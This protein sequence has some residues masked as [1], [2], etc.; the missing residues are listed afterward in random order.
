MMAAVGTGPV[1]S[2]GHWMLRAFAALAALL[3]IAVVVCLE[4]LPSASTLTG[5]E[6]RLEATNG[7]AIALYNLRSAPL[8]RYEGA[9]GAPLRVEVSTARLATLTRSAVAQ[10]DLPVPNV[11]GGA[12]S[13]RGVPPSDGR[14]SVEIRNGRQAPDAGIII[15][16]PGSGTMELGIRAAQTNLLAELAIVPADQSAPGAELRFADVDLNHPSLA[17]TRIAFEVPPGEAISLHFANEERLTA[18]TFR[19]G[20][21]AE[22]AGSPR[23]LAIGR[24]EVGRP[25]DANAFPRLSMVK[26]GLCAARAGDVLLADP[27]PADCELGTERG[28]DRLF[29]T[30][31]DFE[32]GRAALTLAGSGFV[33]ANARARPAASWAEM[34]RNPLVAAVIA[35]LV[36]AAVWPLWRLWRGKGG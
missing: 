19:L 21:P 29:A 33:I 28:R 15:E 3:L 16:Q 4:R 14:V 1:E 25:A 22:A 7:Q 2:T 9:L 6:R 5:S 11:K 23:A 20:E 26:S 10:A 36:L 27:V 31:I 13:W 34:I 18:S 17:T 35:V 30:A 24:A 8:L 12:L 32:P